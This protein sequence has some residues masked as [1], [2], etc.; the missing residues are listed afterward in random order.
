MKGDE[1]GRLDHPSSS[2]RANE[3]TRQVPTVYSTLKLYSIYT[4]IDS[5]LLPIESSPCVFE[6]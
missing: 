1:D 2:S 4:S 3:F 6:I 5:C